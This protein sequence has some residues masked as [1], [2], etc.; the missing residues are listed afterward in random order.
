MTFVTSAMKGFSAESS[1]VNVGAVGRET[2]GEGILFSETVGKLVTI[3]VVLKLAGGTKPIRLFILS[4]A[5]DGLPGEF[6][7]IPGMLIPMPPGKVRPVCGGLIIAAS[8]R[9]PINVL[10][11]W[12]ALSALSFAL[13]IWV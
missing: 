7:D 10:V 8:R 13:D 11:S 9:A 1:V 5:F 6:A 4:N 2:V 12:T 3:G